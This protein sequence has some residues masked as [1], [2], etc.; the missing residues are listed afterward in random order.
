M[1]V[2]RGWTSHALFAWAGLLLSAA[3]LCQQVPSVHASES[4]DLPPVV[5]APV[6][7][8]ITPQEVA[9]IRRCERPF[10]VPGV[11]AVFFF[12]DSSLYR[13][14]VVGPRAGRQKRLIR[15]SRLA[16]ANQEREIV[17]S[18]IHAGRAYVVLATSAAT[19]IIDLD[20]RRIAVLRGLD[21]DRKPRQLRIEHIVMGQGRFV[22]C[23]TSMDDGPSRRID[24]WTRLDLASGEAWL[25]PT[26]WRLERVDAQGAVAAFSGNAVD[27]SDPGEGLVAVDIETGAP[28]PLPAAGRLAVA[29]VFDDP[30]GTPLIRDRPLLISDLVGESALVGVATDQH[31]TYPLRFPRDAHAPQRVLVQG[32][33]AAFATEASDG[34]GDLL[35]A[36][37]RPDTRARRVANGLDEDA[38]IVV[39]GGEH[40]VFGFDADD[41]RRLV[42]TF[43]RHE[44]WDPLEGTS[45]PQ[46]RRLEEHE[47]SLAPNSGS[48]PKGAWAL[49][50]VR[51]SRYYEGG[52][53]LPL[54]PKDIL[55]SPSGRRFAVRYSKWDSYPER[56]PFLFAAGALVY[57]LAELDGTQRIALHVLRLALPD[58]SPPS[59]PAPGAPAKSDVAPPPVG[60]LVY[61]GRYF[62]DEIASPGDGRWLGLME[63]YEKN[64]PTHVEGVCLVPGKPDRYELTPVDV[65]ARAIDTSPVDWLRV[66]RIASPDLEREVLLLRDVPGLRPGPVMAGIKIDNDRCSDWPAQWQLGGALYRVDKVP[67]GAGGDPKAFQVRLSLGS[68]GQSLLTSTRS[69]AVSWAGDLDRDGRLDLELVDH[70]LPGRKQRR[71][72]FLSSMALPGDLVG[73]AG[74]IEAEFRDAG[75]PE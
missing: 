45:T 68:V 44:L 56:P 63:V 64:L 31:V 39:F 70:D 1:L 24:V 37:L 40:C 9:K 20:R 26:S 62:R 8:S 6:L 17:T 18:F 51:V 5:P 14:E 35:M 3:T 66:L 28:V 41:G 46:D 21:R 58:D 71:I 4:D 22:L 42:Y 57:P 60:R 47:P 74:R 29:Y 59:V 27:A 65:T 67:A 11:D 72:A 7:G 75:Q 38:P 34:T 10:V 32:D 36:E 25:F 48:A 49:V 61:S 19:L 50:H 69:A 15:D 13:V 12:R 43:A 33:F 2:I 53:S 73:E 55:L 23:Q 54:T 30:D 52:V 16:D